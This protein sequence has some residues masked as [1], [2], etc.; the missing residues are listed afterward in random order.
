MWELVPCDGREA[1]GGFQGPE[2]GTDGKPLGGAWLHE[3][4]SGTI[5]SL[6]HPGGGWCGGWT[7][8]E[9]VALLT[10]SEVRAGN[11]TPSGGPFPQALPGGTSSQL[12]E[13]GGTSPQLGIG[14]V[15]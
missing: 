14:T 15:G 2:V 3:G 4:L 1:V 5:G 7:E 12:A 8:T 6:G 10:G 11:G 9:G 13:G